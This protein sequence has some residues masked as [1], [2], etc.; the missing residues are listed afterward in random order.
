MGAPEDCDLS[1]FF[2]CPTDRFDSACQIN[3]FL[4]TVIDLVVKNAISARRAA[5]LAYITN[6][7]LRTLPSSSRR[8]RPSS[9]STSRAPSPSRNLSPTTIRTPAAAP[10]HPIPA[11]TPLTAHLLAPA[12]DAVGA[13]Q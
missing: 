10:I 1:D 7:L 11:M 12:V 6:Q 9:S 3:D 4:S 5:V 2:F 13:I 8:T